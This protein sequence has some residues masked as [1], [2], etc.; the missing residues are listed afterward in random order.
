MTAGSTLLTKP[1]GWQTTEGKFIHMVIRLP[2]YYSHIFSPTTPT[3]PG[4]RHNSQFRY[5][6]RSKT[7]LPSP[8]CTTNRT[9]IGR[10][11][12]LGYVQMAV[13]ILHAGYPR[14]HAT[15]GYHSND[16]YPRYSKTPSISMTVYGGPEAW[17]SMRGMG[18]RRNAL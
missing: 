10:R 9:A 7:N 18:K 17:A 6:Q 4:Q 3:Y 16:G 12:P 1:L 2:S 5:L 14:F 13:F 8:F 15:T 11:H